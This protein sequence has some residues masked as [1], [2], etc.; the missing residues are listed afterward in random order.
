MKAIAGWDWKLKTVIM[1][2]LLVLSLTKAFD[3]SKEPELPKPN[4]NK[5]SV[6]KGSSTNTP[7][8]VIAEELLEDQTSWDF[9]SDTNND[10]ENDGLVRWCASFL[11]LQFG[12]SKLVGHT[13]NNDASGF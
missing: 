4:K 11:A 6:P 9:D 8:K 2:N 3:V 13:T 10:E 5:P 7:K 1:V 12:P